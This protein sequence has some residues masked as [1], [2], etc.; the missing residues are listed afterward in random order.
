MARNR[1][2]LRANL[3]EEHAQ[4]C[5][6]LRENLLRS[7]VISVQKTRANWRAVAAFCEQTRAKNTRKRAPIRAKICCAR[8]NFRRKKRAQVGAQSRRF[9]SGRA[10]RLGGPGSSKFAKKIKK[11][12]E[13]LAV[14]K[15]AVFDV[16]S[17]K[18]LQK[19][20]VLSCMDR[21]D[22]F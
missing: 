10:D 13:N 15:R 6:D 4:T 3:R 12:R 22:V 1:G 7:R 8:A 19:W 5:A 2:V 18:K 20:S 21:Y 17:N 11:Y 16:F 9:A 14:S